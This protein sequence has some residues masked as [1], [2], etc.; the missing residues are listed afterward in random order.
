MFVLAPNTVVQGNYIGTDAT[1][2]NALGNAS[3]GVD[4]Q[5]AQQHDRWDDVRG[6]QRHLG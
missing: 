6:A 3:N 2:T 4:V 5:G 1:G